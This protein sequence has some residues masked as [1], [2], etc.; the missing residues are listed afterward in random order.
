LVC[1]ATVVI[2]QASIGRGRTKLKR[3][4]HFCRCQQD[5]PSRATTGLLTSADIEPNPG[6]TRLFQEDIESGGLKCILL[7][8]PVSRF[9]YWPSL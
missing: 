4:Y 8:V 9:C 5:R 6:W 7:K 2:C 3:C 1:R